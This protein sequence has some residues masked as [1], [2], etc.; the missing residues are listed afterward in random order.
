V[1]RRRLLGA[2]AP[3]VLALGCG[4]LLG[5]TDTEVTAAGGTDAVGSV[6]GSAGEVPGAGGTLASDS[7]GTGGA[8]ALGVG[9]GGALAGGGTGGAAPSGDCSEGQGRCVATGREVCTG[10][11]FVASACPVQFPTCEEGACIV[12][13]PPLVSVSNGLF[14]I[15]ATEVTVAQYAQFLAAKNGDVSGQPADLCGWNTTYEPTALANPPE[16][17]ASNID[18]CDARAYCEWAGKHLCR[19]VGSVEPVAYEDLFT[20]GVSQWFT[21]CGGPL[22]AS[23]V[24]ENSNDPNLDSACNA[25]AGFGFLEPVATNSDCEGYYPGVFDLEGNVAEWI[26][27][28]LPSAD[29]GLDSR[30]DRCML[31]GGSIFDFTSFCTEVYDEY[32]RDDTASSFGFRCC[33]G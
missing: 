10:G 24:S 26:D 15:D 14:F 5:I 29:A 3:F 28:C 16:F 4:K 8:D 31:M 13:G 11:V 18:W 19:S 27:S 32:P 23:H 33:A 21:A 6:G 1:N 9:Q 20:T 12:R 22:G 30:N 17:P 7:G 25:N 2:L